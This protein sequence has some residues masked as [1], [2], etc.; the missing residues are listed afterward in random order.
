[1]GDRTYDLDT[2]R[3]CYDQ[4]C[5]GDALKWL[6][7]WREGGRPDVDESVV[8]GTYHSALQDARHAIL[9]MLPPEIQMAV[10]PDAAAFIARGDGAIQ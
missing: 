2:L 6:Q 5:E 7:W 9:A 3:A 1:M 8:I 4:C 10:D